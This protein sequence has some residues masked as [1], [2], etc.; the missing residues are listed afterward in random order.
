MFGAKNRKI[1]ELKLGMEGFRRQMNEWESV[2]I[3]AQA[4]V[5]SLE[6]II[7]VG[8]PDN[9]KLRGELVTLRAEREQF[10]KRVEELEEKLKQANSV[11]TQ[12][13]SA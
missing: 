10:A 9:E 5:R 11:G 2:A 12:S 3:N 8:K 7:S 1:H 6:R 13:D 4:Q